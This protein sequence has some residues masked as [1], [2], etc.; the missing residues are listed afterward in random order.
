MPLDGVVPFP[1][2]FAA[3]Y[4][5]RGYWHDRSLRDVFAEHFD[6]YADRVALIDGGRRHH[7]R[8]ARRACRPPRA[9]PLDLGLRPLDRVVVQLPN[10]APFAY[11]YFALQKIGA[12]PIMALPPHRYREMSSS[13]GCPTRSPASC[14]GGPG[15][16]TSATSSNAS[17][18]RRPGCGCADR[19]RP[20]RTDGFLSLADLLD[21]EPA[22]TAE[23]LAAIAIDPDDPA[24]FQLSGGTTGIPKLIPRTHNDYAYNSRLA[25]SVCDVRDGDVPA[26]RAADRA[27]PAAG[28]PR[29]AGLLVRRARAWCCTRAPA[30]RR[31]S[32]SSSSTA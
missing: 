9:Q 28:L 22:T 31:C 26:G 8:R 21:R 7:L 27:Q 29:P 6:R 23:E 19:R 24:V 18:P 20:G 13:R 3:R 10:D 32:R 17:G 5:E 30:A 16:S 4:R 15:T 14:P 11:L 2:E 12:I 1:A 25:L